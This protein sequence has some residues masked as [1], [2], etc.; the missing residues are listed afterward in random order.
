MVVQLRGIAFGHRRCVQLREGV[1]AEYLWVRDASASCIDVAPVTH[2][3]RSASSASVR[4]SADPSCEVLG[5]ACRVAR[6]GSDSHWRACWLLFSLHCTH[7]MSGSFGYVA[8]L[9]SAD[10][11]HVYVAQ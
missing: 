3:A 9:S 1:S 5:R 11:A 7:R 8:V 4:C 2:G 6:N 10:T